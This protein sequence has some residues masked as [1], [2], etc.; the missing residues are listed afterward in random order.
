MLLDWVIDIK[1][2]I[3]WMIYGC[4]NQPIIFIKMCLCMR[5]KMVW[6]YV[7]TTTDIIIITNETIDRIYFNGIILWEK[8]ISINNRLYLVHFYNGFSFLSSVLFLLWEPQTHRFRTLYNIDMPQLF[9][10]ILCYFVVTLYS[11]N[12]W[13]TFNDGGIA[14]HTQNIHRII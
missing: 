9:R 10:I 1:L 7:F 2:A 14:H 13:Q 4:T 5:C 8:K 11:P 3:R 12:A 6:F